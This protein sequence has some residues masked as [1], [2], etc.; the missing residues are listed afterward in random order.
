MRLKKKTIEVLGFI[1]QHIE[2]EGFPPTRKEIAA[3]F[4]WNSQTAVLFHLD[5]LQAD[6]RIDVRPRVF[7]GIKVLQGLD[8]SGTK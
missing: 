7:R 8:K 3:H 2:S 6:N 4:G 5:K 1:N